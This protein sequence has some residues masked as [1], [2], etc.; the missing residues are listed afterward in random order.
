MAKEKR[1]MSKDQEFEIFKLVMD[2]FL[3]LGF[4]I[5][6]FGL[7]QWFNATITD[8]IYYVIFGVAVLLMFIIIIV[9]EYEL[10]S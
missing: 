5:M 10:L 3:W 8:G 2:K 6:A 1:R 4:G 7:Y 9:R